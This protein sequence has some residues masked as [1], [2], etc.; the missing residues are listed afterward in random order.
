MVASDGADLRVNHLRLFVRS[1]AVETGEALGRLGGEGRNP[2]DAVAEVLDDAWTGSSATRAGFVEDVRGLGARVRAAFEATRDDLDAQVD[3][4]ERMIDVAARPVGEVGHGADPDEL[5]G[6]VRLETGLVD[7]KDRTSDL[8]EGMSAH[9]GVFTKNSTAWT[10]MLGVLTGSPVMLYTEPQAVL[11][12]DETVEVTYP[13]QDPD[14]DP[15]MM[16]V[17]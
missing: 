14:Y 8:L 9:G 4:S 6:V 2:L 17:P 3:A 10:N 12:A 15:P 5:A 7:N 13:M 11:R 16:A 1:A